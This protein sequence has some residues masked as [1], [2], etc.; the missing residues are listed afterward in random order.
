MSNSIEKAIILAA[1][2]ALAQMVISNRVN[3]AKV[4]SEIA[5]YDAINTTL[6]ARTSCWINNEHR[7]SLN[8]RTSTSKARKGD[9]PRVDFG[10]GKGKKGSPKSV[11]TLLEI[12]LASRTKLESSINVARDIEKLYFAQPFESKE[13]LHETAYLIVFNIENDASP[14]ETI[15]EIRWNEPPAA[16]I[17]DC[18][19]TLSYG[20]R[21]EERLVYTA[22]VFRIRRERRSVI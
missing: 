10:I 16:E 4:L 22:S 20:V 1:E 21:G 11:V 18:I 15:G 6:K 13:K 5:L 2:V 17:V 14:S 9:A 3:G 19:E 8:G 7:V 12:K